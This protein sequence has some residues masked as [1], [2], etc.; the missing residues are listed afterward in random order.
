MSSG[1]RFTYQGGFGGWQED[2]VY[3]MSPCDLDIVFLDTSMVVQATPEGMKCGP[4]RVL[5]RGQTME[6]HVDKHMVEGPHTNYFK[7]EIQRRP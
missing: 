7:E 4:T 2:V 3:S 5:P 6:V 1:R